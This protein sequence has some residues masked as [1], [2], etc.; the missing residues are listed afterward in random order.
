M[1]QYLRS[2]SGLGAGFGASDTAGTLV[3]AYWNLWQ[4]RPILDTQSPARSASLRALP[5]TRIHRKGIRTVAVR[6]E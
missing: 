4:C 5:G 2:S 6:V 3:A 1:I